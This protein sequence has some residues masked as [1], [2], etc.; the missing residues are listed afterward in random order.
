MP[1]FTLPAY[2]FSSPFL[3]TNSGRNPGLVQCQQ[4][5]SR[6]RRIRNIILQKKHYVSPA[7][8]AYVF[9]LTDIICRKCHRLK[10]IFREVRYTCTYFAGR[11]FPAG[12]IRSNLICRFHRYSI[13]AD[14]T[15]CPY[16]NLT[17]DITSASTVSLPAGQSVFHTGPH[18]LPEPVTDIPCDNLNDILYT[19]K[20]HLQPQITYLVTYPSCPHC[21]YLPRYSLGTD[22]RRIIQHI[23]IYSI[24]HVCIFYIQYM[25]SYNT[26]LPRCPG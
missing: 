20:Y 18:T 24:L 2:L 4:D 26:V 8:Q 9:S 15:L 6:L 17:A 5:Y 16:T 10:I 3:Q 22:Y 14:S 23:S 7:N 12:Y 11:G 13:T 25:Y 1:F 19:G 21:P